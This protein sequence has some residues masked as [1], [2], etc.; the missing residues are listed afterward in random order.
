MKKHVLA[1][2]ALLVAASAAPAMAERPVEPWELGGFIGTTLKGQ[3]HAPLGIVGAVDKENGIIAMVGPQGQVA[4][5]HTSMLVSTGSANL[6]A[7][8]L[9]I[10]DIA[11]ASN[12][13]QSNVP[14]VAPRI[15]VGEPEY[16][17]PEYDEYGRPL[18]DEYGEP[19]YYDY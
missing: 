13:G 7:P 17:G 16:S 9:T 2:S 4:T 3:G 18:Y 10:G 6:R 15:I 12:T 1:L 11:Y 14:F 5:V 8:L 19:L